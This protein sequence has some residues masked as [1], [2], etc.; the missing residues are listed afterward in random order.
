MILCFKVLVEEGV[1]DGVHQDEERLDDG[2]RL[3]DAEYAVRGDAELL[4]VGER[5]E[6]ERLDAEQPDDGELLFV[7]KY[8]VQ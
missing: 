3:Y 7:V 1:Q 2:E 4:D 8:T 5:L 6:E